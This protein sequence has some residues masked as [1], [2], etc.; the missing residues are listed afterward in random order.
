MKEDSGLGLDDVVK[1]ETV[2][3]KV[4]I[5]DLSDTTADEGFEDEED[6][7]DSNIFT[8]SLAVDKLNLMNFMLVEDKQKKISD[9]SQII[10]PHN[11]HSKIKP[12]VTFC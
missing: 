12:E 5:E 4:E 1:E 7:D 8:K 11:F 3:E 9:V 10:A 2:A 6:D